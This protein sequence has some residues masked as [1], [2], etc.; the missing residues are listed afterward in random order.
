M[1]KIALALFLLPFVVALF[2]RFFNKFKLRKITKGLELE[3]LKKL[4]ELENIAHDDYVRYYRGEFNNIEWNS[5]FFFL[6]SKEET[7][8]AIAEYKSLLKGIN[9][10]I[11]VYSDRA[12][13]NIPA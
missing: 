11:A 10:V 2:L 6:F 13:T 5:L 4:Q 3:V 8:K 1:W 7:E 9:F 12:T